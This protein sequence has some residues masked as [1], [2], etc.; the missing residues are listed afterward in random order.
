MAS[1]LECLIFCI[2]FDENGVLFP[3]WW[4]SIKSSQSSTHFF[5]IS[6]H[7]LANICKFLVGGFYAVF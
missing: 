7:P 5:L 3:N 4:C 1:V 2:T 6:S